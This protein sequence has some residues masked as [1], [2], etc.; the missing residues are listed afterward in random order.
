MA[1]QLKLL[2]KVKK[3]SSNIA[4][5]NILRAGIINLSLV[6]MRVLFA[7]GPYMKKY[8]KLFFTVVLRKYSRVQ[9]NW[10]CMFISGN[11][12]LLTLIEAKRQTLPKI[13]VHGQLFG[14][15]NW[16]VNKLNTNMTIVCPVKMEYGWNF[17]ISGLKM[18]MKN[19]LEFFFIEIPPRGS[20]FLVPK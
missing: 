4:H 15:L 10:P 12:C 5:G 6:L 2:Q 8:G 17:S 9:N 13:N 3:K 7:G 14:T 16:V 19:G 11:V 18:M 1:I 20:H